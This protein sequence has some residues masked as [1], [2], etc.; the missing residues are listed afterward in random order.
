MKCQQVTSNIENFLDGHM[1]S[2]GHDALLSHVNTCAS[3][4]AVLASEKMLRQSLKA[5]PEVQVNSSFIKKAMKQAHRTHNPVSNY[6]MS[7]FMTAVT[8][9]FAIWFLTSTAI[10]QPGNESFPLISMAVNEAHTVQMV[11]DSPDSFK[12]VTFKLSLPEGFEVAGYPGHTELDWEVDIEKGSNVLALP[13]LALTSGKGELVAS[14]THTNKIKS[15]RLRVSSE[16]L[17]QLT[18]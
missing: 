13:I 7:G 6:F 14:I 3:C 16:K 18:L 15:F 9:S 4:R 17:K 12:D 11:F 2:L 10:M 8:A 1:A 5:L